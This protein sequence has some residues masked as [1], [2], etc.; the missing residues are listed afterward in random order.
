MASYSARFV[1]V[2]SAAEL[3][4]LIYRRPDGG[5]QVQV[6]FLFPLDLFSRYTTA[7]LHLSLTPEK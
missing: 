4:A 3:S 6:Y 2:C 1:A 5:L 7:S